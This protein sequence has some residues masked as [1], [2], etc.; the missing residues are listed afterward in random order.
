M[1]YFKL[2]YRLFNRRI[3]IKILTVFYL[4]SQRS[5][6]YIQISKTIVTVHGLCQ[7]LQNYTHTKNVHTMYK[8]NKQLE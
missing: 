7:K 6:Q 1:N 4:Q 3:F 5:S 2:T 8:R